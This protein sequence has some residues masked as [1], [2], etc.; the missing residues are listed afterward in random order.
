MK[1]MFQLLIIAFALLFF[2]LASIAQAPNLGTTAGFLLFSTNGAVTNS[3]ISQ[4]TGNIGTNNG[5]NTGFGNVNGTM[6]SQNGA[7]AQAAQD[8]LIA[9]NQLNGATPTF[10]PSNLLGNGATLNSGVYSIA[11]AT[12]LNGDLTLDA[13]GNSGAVFIFKIQGAFSTNANAKVKLV[14]GAK[15]CN[16]FWKVEGLVSFASGTTMRGTVIANNAAI[17][18]NAGD[19]LEGRAFSTTGAVIMNGTFAYIPM[20]CGSPTL[21]GPVAPNL[22]SNAGYA[23]FSS[24]GNVSNTGITHVNGGDVGTNSGTTTGFDTLLVSGK[25]HLTPDSSTARADTDLVNTYSY[26]NLLPIDIELLYPAQFGNNLVLTPHTY[27]LNAATVLTDT[28][29]LNAQG[30]P[31]AVF[32]IKINGALSTSVGSKVIL[33]N[34]AQV[35]N[36]YWRVDGATVINDSSVFNGTILLTNGALNSGTVV[37]GRVL[38]GIRALTTNNATINIPGVAIPLA[39]LIVSTTTG[40]Q[41]TYNNVTVTST[42]NGTLTGNLMVMGNMIIQTGGKLNTADNLVQGRN[43]FTLSNGATLTINSGNGIMATGE[44]GDIQALGTRTYNTGATYIYAGNLRQNAGDGLPSAIDSLVINNINGVTLS[45]SH[46]VNRNLKLGN[47]NINIGINNLT[48]SSLATI[49]GASVNGYVATDDSAGNRGMLN[50]TVISAGSP[51]LFPVGSSLW[52]GSYSPAT[53]TMPSGATDIISVRVFRGVL[54]M[55]LTGTSITSHVVNRSWVITE[56]VSGGSNATVQLQWND[57]MEL[58]SLLRIKIGIAHHGGTSWNAP[59]VASYI[60]AT[61]SNPYSA[62][63]NSIT[64]L[65]VFIVADSSTNSILPVKL[66]SFSG[67]KIND[68]IV[69]NWKT[70]ME[71]NN[72]H[73]ELERSIDGKS[74]NKVGEIKGTGNSS[75]ITNYRFTDVQI[76]DISNLV[77]YYKLIQVDFDGKMTSYGPIAIQAAQVVN[78]FNFTTF[79]NPIIKDVQIQISNSETGTIHFVIYDVRG[80]MVAQKS[81]MIEAGSNHVTIDNLDGLTRGIYFMHAMLNGNVYTR[82]LVKNINPLF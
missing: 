73:F 59:T 43:N 40:V 41:G 68:D 21:S 52:K 75:I 67:T 26:I 7:T 79:P 54:D 49:T 36:V 66:L 51:V 24:N 35:Q 37:N 8:L 60:A 19:T 30:N 74:F 70:V 5:F 20:G 17:N 42:G 76:S 53:I 11:S 69:L 58:P 44:V 15:A 1:N 65:G 6:N 13:N 12:I 25:I 80:K 64:S 31:S 45:A 3:G 56:A 48:I 4:L 29:Y 10:F 27:L 9:Y 32:V 22:V 14:N 39:N 81:T 72:S 33:I 62:T 82:K 78:E 38:S 47:G 77:I 34:G 28:V 55:G 61:G 46:T 23:L 16:V 50:R 57:T 71:A 63:R 18:M 2:P